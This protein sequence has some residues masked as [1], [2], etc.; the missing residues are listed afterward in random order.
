MHPKKKPRRSVQAAVAILIAAVLSPGC[1]EDKLTGT[2][3]NLPPNSM[4]A[5]PPLE[6]SPADLA[7]TAKSKPKLKPRN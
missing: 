1:A 3:T 2:P 5:P 6:Q 7:K 4:P